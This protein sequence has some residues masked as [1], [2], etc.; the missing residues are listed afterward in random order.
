MVQPSRAKTAVSPG[1]T[2]GAPVVEEVVEEHV[3]PPAPPKGRKVVEVYED[4][5]DDDQG[6][7]GPDGYRTVVVKHPKRSVLPPPP[8]HTAKR[9]FGGRF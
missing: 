6:H 1:R 3:T 8:R 9:W 2:P 4:D 5:D 7:V